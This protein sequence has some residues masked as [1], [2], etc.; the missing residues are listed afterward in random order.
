MRRCGRRGGVPRVPAGPDRVASHLDPQGERLGAK[1]RVLPLQPDV[2]GEL[3][4][5]GGV[6]PGRLERSD[7]RRSSLSPAA[8][9]VIA[10][11]A[12]IEPRP[13]AIDD[14]HYRLACAR[15]TAALLGAA[16]EGSHDRVS[17]PTHH[18]SEPLTHTE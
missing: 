5:R 18:E 10:W 3:R 17:G 12:A 4:V 13:P 11:I 2:R 7:D 8:S 15:R 16:P 6:R 9:R 1:L 14:V